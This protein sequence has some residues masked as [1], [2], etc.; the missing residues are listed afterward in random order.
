[1]PVVSAF[2]NPEFYSDS[3]M[4]LV[5]VNTKKT[6]STLYL[7]GR[8]DYIC[9]KIKKEPGY[10]ERFY[11]ELYTDSKYKNKIIDY[12]TSGTDNSQYVILP[13]VFDNMKSG[14]YYA[15]TYV[16]KSMRGGYEYNLD[17]STVRTYKI[18]VKKSGTSIKDMN[19]VMYGY[20]NTVN[21][22]KIYWFGVPDATGYYL[23][24]KNVQ[25]GKY[26]K[27]KTVKNDSQKITSCVDKSLKDVNVTRYYKVVA[28]K[29]T[30]KTPLSQLSLKVK[31]LKTPNVKA[32]ILSNDRV[33]LTWSKVTKGAQ[34]TVYRRTAESD[35][36]E[37][38]SNVEGTSYIDT[39][40]KENKTYY[41]TVVARTD[42]RTSGYMTTGAKVVY[43]NSPKMKACTYTNDG[44]IVI[45]W[46]VVKGVDGYRI[47]RK[48]SDGDKW[49]KLTDVNNGKA[50]SYIDTTANNV[51]L[52]KYTVRG[53]RD[54]KLGSYSYAGVKATV[55]TQPKLL[56]ATQINTTKVRISWEKIP[57][58]CR[59]NVFMKATD[60]W[61]SIGKTSAD[62]FEYNV[63]FE[64]SDY[65]FTVSAIRSDI[66]SSYDENGVTCS[67]Y[68]RIKSFDFRA[69]QDGLKLN[70]EKP[71]GAGNTLVYRKT[72]DCEYELLCETELT[73]YLD[74]SA[75][76]GVEYTYKLLY[77]YNGELIENSAIEK[78]ITIINEEIKIVDKVYSAESLNHGYYYSLKID[79]F[80]K[81]AKYSIYLKND[82]GEWVKTSAE[83]SSKGVFSVSA[84]VKETEYAIVKLTDDGKIS[85]LPENG[86]IVTNPALP[87]D[88]TIKEQKNNDNTITSITVTWD[89]NALDCEEICIK[90]SGEVIA[91]VPVSEGVFVCDDIPLNEY[92][93]YSAH[94]KEGMFVSE[95]A[96]YLLANNMKAPEFKL[97]RSNGIKISVVDDVSAVRLYRIYRK[98][99]G[100][101]KWTKVADIVH[102]GYP[103]AFKNY[104]IDTS[105]ENLNTYTY[106]VR[107]KDYYGKWSPFDKQGL[108]FRYIETPGPIKMS[109]IKNGFKVTWGKVDGCDGYTL[110]YYDFELNKWSEEKIL[111]GE[112]SLTYI[113]TD[114]SSGER[115]YYAIRAFSGDD[116][117]IY[118]K[119][120]NKIY[121]AQPEIASL[122]SEKNGVNIEF[123]TVNGAQG[124]Y[125][126]RKSG[127]S[128]KWTKIAKVKAGS[129]I[130]KNVEKGKKYTYTVKAY[131]NSD[132]STYNTKGKSIKF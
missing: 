98:A 69:A 7:Y 89:K 101:M 87:Q 61:Y 64:V 74:I 28:Y 113:D 88:L 94:A 46:S 65:T 39:F 122:T 31:T 129:Y 60:S 95:K 20:E 40:D 132:I 13:I 116:V 115:R 103:Y 6:S 83:I 76:Q 34:Y 22:P 72:P 85:V 127:S 75:E 30:A 104:Y 52:Y 14:T 77:K 62:Y 59:Y 84:N 24:R 21:G 38:K 33:E 99:P 124:Y 110:K 121:L 26:E 114:I 90:K 47:Y 58:N 57:N 5:D 111:K 91:C 8:A 100:E 81:T 93:S 128:T 35:W 16:R 50:T 108:S 102:S 41:Y 37:L 66:S 53:I 78:N 109:R 15:K 119:T 10:F 45:N 96:V 51:D 19:T 120:I 68:P 106:T 79:D 9:L 123:N 11:F 73:E 2:D 126:Y 130:D 54:G 86:F 23:Y 125:L 71:K 4:W 107:A 118:R 131:Y 97:S 70:W 67:V 80:D 1:M 92:L 117:S 32:K 105:V 82:A 43:S 27:I 42:E 18:V 12:D 49:E 55:L 112:N 36:T 25:T 29:G 48:L 63:P 44:G 56:D 17:D 3:D